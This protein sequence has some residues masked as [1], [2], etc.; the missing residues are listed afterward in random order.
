MAGSQT[1]SNRGH[2][3]RRVTKGLIRYYGNQD[4][5]F[6]TCSCYRRQPQ[7]KTSRRRDLLLKILE[8]TRRKY[9]FVVHGYVAMPE[10]F[11][12]L[13]TEPEVGDPSV[14]MKVLNSALRG[15]C[16]PSENGHL[17]R[18]SRSGIRLPIR[19]GRSVFTI[20]MSGRSESE[21]RNYVTCIAIR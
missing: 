18:R 16:I 9:R 3:S 1:T 7:M 12:V 6:I 13:M 15:A 20:S 8:E 14:V 2:Y 17:R 21:S 4:L 5:H 10:H 19:F 11:H